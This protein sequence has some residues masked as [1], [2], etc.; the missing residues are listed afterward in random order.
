MGWTV[1]A[2][3][4]LCYLGPIWQGHLASHSFRKCPHGKSPQAHGEAFRL[5]STHSQPAS[6]AGDPQALRVIHKIAG[7]FLLCKVFKL[8]TCKI[9]IKYSN[10]HQLSNQL[11]EVCNN[12]VMWEL[13]R[14]KYERAREYIME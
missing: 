14:L 10:T 1:G 6:L 4:N 5:I 11:G 9:A 7:V 8:P 13:T 12:L 2:W 3:Y